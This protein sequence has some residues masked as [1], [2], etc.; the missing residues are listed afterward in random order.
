VLDLGWQPAS[1]SFPPA[2]SRAPDER[3]P[4]TLWLCTGC[5][6][7]QLGADASLPE[8]PLAVESETMKRHAARVSAAVLTQSGLAPGATVAE[9]ASHHGGSWLPHLVAAGLRP[10]PLAADGQADLVVDVHGLAHDADTDAA[11]AAHASRLRPDGRLVLEFHHLLPLLVEGQFDTVRHGHPVYLSLLALGPA[12]AR[13]GL[14]VTSAQQSTAYGGSLQVTA[15]PAALGVGP[16]A[17]VAQ[18]LAAEK[19]AGVDQAAA[20]RGLHAQAQRTGQA[21]RDY[22]AAARVAGRVVLGYGAPSKASVLLCSSNI[23]PDLLPFTADLSPAKTGRR[24]AGCA[25]PIRSPADLLA[26]RP[27]EVLIL[28]WDI[29]HEVAEQLSVVLS[30]GGRF[31]VPVPEPHPLPASAGASGA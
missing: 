11:L 23:G 30:W 18:V 12:L 8:V 20:L 21:L 2:D 19:A 9:A 15:R 31:T 29:A 14:A 16:D 6:L 25:V 24:L 28:T 22:L 4:L 13:H 3:W 27:D 5:A 26:A 7:V 1:D 10:I 17:S